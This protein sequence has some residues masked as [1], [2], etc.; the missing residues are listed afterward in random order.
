MS[1][2]NRR[3][4]V[5]LATVI[6][7]QGSVPRR[8]GAKMLIYADGRTVGSVGGGEME[9][10]IVVAAQDAL[11]SGQSQVIPYSLVDPGRG[12]P[13]VCGGNV[14]I[15]VEPYLPQATLYIFGCGHVGQSLA[16]LGK[17]LGYR[18]VAHDDRPDLATADHMPD[19]DAVLTGPIDDILAAEPLD[20]HT[21]AALVTRNVVLDRE[22]LPAILAS[23]VPYIGVM[24]SRR[25]WEE[26][27]RLLLADGVSP[28]SL[29]R[30]TSPIGL[31]LHAETPNEIAV[32]IMAQIISLRSTKRVTSPGDTS[33]EAAPN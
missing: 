30:I 3:I 1:A 32:S 25:R 23:P 16:A 2:R 20:E 5:A 14:E 18:V 31:E 13:G 21:Y 17:W 9:S 33:R 15:F 26:T 27:R 10:R 22:L 6:R 8:A 7:A 11:G 29:D 28:E 24:G 12:D 19:A 4:P